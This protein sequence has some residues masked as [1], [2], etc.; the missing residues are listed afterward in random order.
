MA[1]SDEA[2]LFCIRSNA[3]YLFFCG[4]ARCGIQTLMVAKNGAELILFKFGEN[5]KLIEKQSRLRPIERIKVRVSYEFHRLPVEVPEEFVGWQ[6]E[7]G[8]KHQ[9]ISVK[10]FF[11]EESRIGI[12]EL[13]AHYREFVADPRGYIEWLWEGEDLSRDTMFRRNSDTMFRAPVIECTN[14]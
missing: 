9:T 5:G 14:S 12:E 2:R 11:D 1:P 8:L 4:I 6:E 7:I 10:K 13:P 3:Y